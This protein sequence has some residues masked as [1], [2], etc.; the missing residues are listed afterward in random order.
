M[1]PDCRRFAPPAPPAD[2]ERPLIHCQPQLPSPYFSP[3]LATTT[4]SEGNRLSLG[5]SQ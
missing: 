4:L 3:Q 2:A 5:I 1:T